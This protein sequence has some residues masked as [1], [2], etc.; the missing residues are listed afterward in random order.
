MKASQDLVILAKKEGREMSKKVLILCTGNSCRSILA[1][2][3]AYRYLKDR[4]VEV[5]SAGS[6]PSGRVHPHARRLLQEKNLWR[7]AFHSKS[8]QTVMEHRPFDLVVT[9]CDNARESCPMVP[10]SKHLHI[11]FEDP[12][13]KPYATFIETLEK[14]ER[15][16]LPKLEEALR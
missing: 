15:E 13:G 9:V 8:I 2:A 5:F 14:I 11:P 7:D 4:D 16:L 12:D 10:G 6:H 3:A 1:E